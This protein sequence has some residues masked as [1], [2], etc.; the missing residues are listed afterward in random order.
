MYLLFETDIEFIR[1]GTNDIR[2]E[3]TIS[4]GSSTVYF[5]QFLLHP[6]TLYLCFSV[7]NLIASKGTQHLRW[8]VFVKRRSRETFQ[9][10]ICSNPY[11]FV[12][13]ISDPHWAVPGI[14]I[15]PLLLTIWRWSDTEIFNCELKT[16]RDNETRTYVLDIR[17]AIRELIYCTV[18]TATSEI[19]PRVS[20]FVVPPGYTNVLI[21]HE[22]Y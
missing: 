10:G 1:G 21:V 16:F 11:F 2:D 9:D 6:V 14:T 13:V 3:S 8:L 19:K 18:E 4:F 15:F 20:W 17:H 7:V 5:C 22:K 12:S